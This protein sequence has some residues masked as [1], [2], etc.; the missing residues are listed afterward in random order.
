MLSFGGLNLSDGKK[1]KPAFPP[2]D[3]EKRVNNQMK[4]ISDSYGRAIGRG[5]SE[6]EGKGEVVGEKEGGAKRMKEGRTIE[7]G[8]ETVINIGK[9]KEREGGMITETTKDKER[10]RR[11][12]PGSVSEEDISTMKLPSVT[13]LI[14][15]YATH[16]GASSLYIDN[17]FSESFL[18]Q[19]ESLFSRL[20]VAAP[21]RGAIEC[22]SRSYYCD[23]IGW[24]TEGIAKALICLKHTEKANRRDDFHVS[25]NIQKNGNREMG[26]G[27][28]DGEVG[29]DT[30]YLECERVKGEREEQEQGVGEREGQRE[31]EGEGEGEG[32]TENGGDGWDN[33]EMHTGT[34]KTRNDT[35]STT[36]SMVTQ[37]LPHMRFLNYSMIGSSS[38]PHVDLSRRTK[39]NRRST[40]TF[41]LYLTDCYKGGETRLL[42][43]VNPRHSKGIIKGGNV[44]VGAEV[45]VGSNDDSC[46]EKGIVSK[47]SG[48][49]NSNNDN[50]DNNK[51]NY[52][53]SNVHV[54]IHNDNNLDHNSNSNNI[55]YT[56]PH[57]TSK[58]EEEEGS[59]E[60]DENVL[61]CIAPR[62]GRLLIFPHYCPHE[63]AHTISLPK[64]LLR[65]EMIG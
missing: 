65:G 11:T 28:E 61:S 24:V 9:I 27:K 30:A 39:D 22:A 20:P 60:T 51:N 57:K 37:A 33:E 59:S 53:S 62:R 5:G 56:N 38:P 21:E 49:D 14:P 32:G 45:E 13:Y 4:E 23:S 63:G 55:N 64:I 35:Q 54:D 42:R 2:V 44:G 19:L 52:R 16:A 3:S 50:I 15:H 31:I 12:I 46:E 47:K 7:E 6:G 40:H 8:I 29:K 48:I 18:L 41:L 36:T 1:F 17:V 58:G 43:S 25:F 10:E 26:R 34:E